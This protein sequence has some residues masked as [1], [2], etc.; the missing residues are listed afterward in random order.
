MLLLLISCTSAEDQVPMKSGEVN[1]PN[2]YQLEVTVNSL[3]DHAYELVIKT[4]L[5]EGAYFVSPF[6]KGDYK[7]QFSISLNPNDRIKWAEDLTESPRSIET[8]NPWS[9]GPVNYV[10]ENT[11]YTQSFNVTNEADFTIGGEIQFVIE[12]N[13]TMEKIPFILSQRNGKV[14]GQL[15]PEKYLKPHEYGG[16]SCPDNFN[17]PPVNVKELGQIPI[18]NGRL[19]T[20][21]ETRNGTSLIYIDLEKYPD[22]KPLDMTFPRLA[23]CYSPHTK[24]DEMVIVIQGVV[25]GEDTIA[26]Y[27]YLNGGNGSAWFHEVNFLTEEEVAQ[28][29][30]TRFVDI[31][32]EVAPG[33]REL[34][35]VIKDGDLNQK[36]GKKF[37]EQLTLDGTVVKG[38]VTAHWDDLY[39]QVDYNLEG[40]HYVEKFLMLKD[41]KDATTEFH[42]VAGPIREGFEAKQEAWQKWYEEVVA[43]SEEGK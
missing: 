41:P 31:V 35:S 3:G 25:I 15:T 23:R 34:W 18:V 1:I 33:P 32:M 37:D 38:E 40:Y 5:A 13:C 14:T 27:R 12:P 8:I 7:G 20:Q 28:L 24:K 19:P 11:V 29:E 6:S 30:P 42:V 16:W 10:T 4:Q 36:M 26:G 9:G 39:L 21:E 43:L 2:P 22:A 17:F